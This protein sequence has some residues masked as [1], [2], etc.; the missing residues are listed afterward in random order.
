V[1]TATAT[2]LTPVSAH[3]NG[4]EWRW[5][6]AKHPA[7]SRTTIDVIETGEEREVP[8]GARRVAFGFGRVLDELPAPDGWAEHAD[9][10]AG[11]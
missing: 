6:T 5:R 9:L 1:T 3:W 11:P 4:D 2:T 7:P 10:V 8:A